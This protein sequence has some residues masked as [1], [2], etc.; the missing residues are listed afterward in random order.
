MSLLPALRAPASPCMHTAWGALQSN[1]CWEQ[2]QNSSN[3]PQ[4]GG[5]FPLSP[6]YSWFLRALWVKCHFS[7]FAHI[8]G[9]F[10]STAS[11]SPSHHLRFRL[12]LFHFI[13]VFIQWLVMGSLRPPFVVFL[14]LEFLVSDRILF[15]MLFIFRCILPKWLGTFCGL[16]HCALHILYSWVSP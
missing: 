9:S 6:V 15:S 5:N 4:P 1:R 14:P 12:N 16:I 10:P 8:C 2:P 13:H 7:S 3:A 11:L